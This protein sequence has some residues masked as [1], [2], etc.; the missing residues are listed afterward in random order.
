MPDAES[1]ADA[2]FDDVA[3][4]FQCPLRPWSRTWVLITSDSGQDKSLQGDVIMSRERY[5]AFKRVKGARA[6][7]AAASSASGN[8]DR[9]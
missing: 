5:P 6:G 4:P 1:R 2:M 7:S 9:D 3:L 8:D